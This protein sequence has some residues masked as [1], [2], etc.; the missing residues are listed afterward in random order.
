MLSMSLI[1]CQTSQ[2]RREDAVR[3]REAAYLER[4]KREMAKTRKCPGG[5]IQYP[6]FQ[7]SLPPKNLGMLPRGFMV[8]PFW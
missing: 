8:V 1:R 7:M 2:L 6:L 3:A 5:L 4:M